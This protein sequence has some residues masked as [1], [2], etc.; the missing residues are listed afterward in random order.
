MTVQRIPHMAHWGAFTAA[1]EN[2]RLVDVAPHA[3]DPDPSPL[4]R[5]FVGALDHPVRIGRPMIREGWLNDG[6]GPSERRGRDRFV[7]VSWD[8][9]LD[10]LAGELKRVYSGFGAEAI[11]GG[12]Y[13]WASAGR[14]HHALSQVHR[15][16]NVQGGY[17]ASRHSYSLGASE[18]IVPHVVGVD[19]F[20]YFQKRAT[21]WEELA[22]HTD[23]VVAFGGLP[24]KNAAVTGGG[25][26]KHEARA[27]LEAMKRRGCR[28]VMFGPI[29]DD[30]AESLGAEWHR[31]RPGSDMAVMLALAHELVRQGRV[32]RAFLAKYC[33]GWER[34]EPYLTGAADGVA[35]TPAWAASLAGISAAAIA[36]VAARMGAGQTLVTTTWSVQRQEGGE[37]PVWMS[38]VLAAMLGQI[39]LPGGGFGHG[40]ACTSGMGNRFIAAI[41]ALPQLRNPVKRFIPVARIADMLLNP[42]ALFDYDGQRLTY[43][44]I[45]LVYWCG[46]NPFHHHQDLFRLARAFGRVDTF[47]THEPFWTAAA[48]HADIVLPATVTL[49][50]NDIGGGANS[51]HVLA[52]KRALAP[53]GQARDDYAIFAALARRLGT[54]AAF[55]EGRDE[56]GWLEHLYERWRQ[57]LEDRLEPLPAFAEFWRQGLVEMVPRQASRQVFLSEF[58]ADPEAAPLKTPSGR[59][60]VFS[61]RIAGYGYAGEPGHPVWRAPAE[62]L[63]GARAARFPIQLVANNPASRLHGQLD[64]GAHSQSTKVAGREPIRINPADAARRGIKDGDVVKVFNDR[65]ACL[66]GAVVS[67]AV[68][69]GVA[70]LSTG[71]W[72]DPQDVPGHG[73]ICAHGNPNVLTA[74]I[75]A[76]PLSQGCTGQLVLAELA[77][78][79]GAPPPVRAFDPPEIVG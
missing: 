45:K 77:R 68:M 79:D 51:R 55:T 58:R 78:F 50:R 33:A 43:P 71:A 18:V 8:R 9:A 63:G 5:N 27:Y 12:S 60:E 38:V 44:A 41:P 42:G 6:P 53:F 47:V 19:V 54:E 56:M 39:G 49:E 20:E 14:F 34:F 62:W 65:G 29:R 35:K 32:D 15:F 76:S 48:R 3:A 10:L 30:M 2:G 57:G 17:V 22:Q 72:F 11:F 70:Q 24:L 46:G 13:G 16:L 28:F 64:H 66:A 7:A 23:L 52:M 67:D 37:Q 40:Y 73:V 4:V 59:I 21:S 61:P 36:D 31:I 26:L 69:E 74:D 25:T 1:I 75:G